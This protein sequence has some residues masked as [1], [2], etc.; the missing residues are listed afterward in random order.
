[1]NGMNPKMKVPSLLAMATA[2]SMNPVMA[3]SSVNLYG[4][5]DL[6]VNAVNGELSSSRYMSSGGN[7]TSRWGV[8]GR[9]DLGGSLY[10]GFDLEAQVDAD[11][12]VGGATNTN[13]QSNG[14]SL[15][16][17]STFNRYSIL[18][19][20]GEFGEL[21]L[22]RDYTAHYRNRVDVDPFGNQGIASSQAQAGSLGGTTNTRASNMINYVTPPSLGGFYAV[23]NHYLGENPSG[24]RAS[25]DGTGSSLRLG[26]RAGPWLAAVSQGRT[27]YATTATNGDITSTNAALAYDFGPVRLMGGVYRDRVERASPQVGKGFIVAATAPVGA[28]E[29]KAAYSR[30]GTD[31][32]GDPDT[33]KLVIGYVH[34]LSTRTAL[35]TNAVYV[36]NSGGAS[37]SLA[38]SN[39]NA[40]GTSKGINAGIRHAF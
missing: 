9:E 22:G 11:S 24:N 8:R 28:H 19:F 27:S 20:G 31:A 25:K 39:T 1:M 29:L 2:F 17:A 10:V 3:Q 40:N 4:I 38:G 15:A 6:T 37:V 12:G 18:K 36:K 32:A 5:V 23:V 13:N 35:F 21:R 14:V 33:G 30:Y 16:G 7:S 26:Y 34:N